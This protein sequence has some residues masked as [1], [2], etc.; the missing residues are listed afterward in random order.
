[1]TTLKL[2]LLFRMKDPTSINSVTSPITSMSLGSDFPAG[3]IESGAARSIDSRIDPVCDPIGVG[4]SAVRLAVF[5]LIS[6]APSTI[7]KIENQG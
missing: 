7:T 1:M 5:N 6:S 3:P 4:A 2:N